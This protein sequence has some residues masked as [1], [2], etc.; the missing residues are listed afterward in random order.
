VTAT[1]TPWQQPPLR[2]RHAGPGRVAWTPHL[3]HAERTDTG[4]RQRLLG[5]LPTLR[6]CCARDPFLLAAWWHVVEGEMR[7]WQEDEGS[8]RCRCLARDRAAILNKLREKAPRPSRTGRAAFDAYRTRKEEEWRRA[9]EAEA[10]EQARRQAGGQ[11]WR[12]AFQEEVWVLGGPPHW[13]EVLGVPRSASLAEVKARWRELALLHHPDRHGDA[14]TFMRVQ[15]AYE[16]AEK[17][18]RDRR[19]C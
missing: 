14:A 9:V 3:V 17:E 11:E 18:L 1:S 8:T 5:R 4:P 7:F 19:A 15:A 10:A 12:H 16:Q 13:S 2:C 6:S